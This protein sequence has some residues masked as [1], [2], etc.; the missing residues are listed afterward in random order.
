MLKV[1]KPLVTAN[2]LESVK[3]PTGG[4][5]LA[6]PANEISV[7]EIIEAV[8]GAIAASCPRPR[9]RPLAGPQAPRICSEGAEAIR[10]TLEKFHVSD[11][12]NASRK[13]ARRKAKGA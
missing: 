3:G 8:D 10:A 4:Y 6:C 12:V 5:K 9:C 11:L 7:L 1:L 13:P 2:L